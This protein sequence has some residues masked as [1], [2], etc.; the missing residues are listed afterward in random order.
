MFENEEVEIEK[1]PTPAAFLTLVKQL[2]AIA[3]E[4]EAVLQCEESGAK[5]ANLQGFLAGVRN[6]KKVMHDNGY[7]FDIK[8]EGTTERGVSFF[9]DDGCVLELAELI[10]IKSD[11]DEFTETQTFAHFK[12]KWQQA[13][14]TKK[15][16]VILHQR[17]RTR[18]AFLQGLV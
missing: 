3:Y 5:V 7:E 8:Y 1:V 4:K 18:P 13:V 16:L 6:Y 2:N 10:V 9:D 17:K 15:R 14:E 11:I 12:D